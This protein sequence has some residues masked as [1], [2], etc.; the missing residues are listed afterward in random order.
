MSSLRSLERNIFP[1][2]YFSNC[3]RTEKLRANRSKSPLSVALFYFQGG[4]KDNKS[5]SRDFLTSL[6]KNTRETDIK[7]WVDQD[8]IGIILPDTDEKGLQRC[9]EKIKNGDENRNYRVVSATYPHFLFERL[10]AGTENPPDIFPIEL[11]EVWHSNA[12][13]RFGKRCMDIAGSFAGI[14][15]LSPLMVLIC[16][17]IKLDS[18]GPVIFRQIRHGEKGSRFGFLKFRSMATNCD[19]KA[20]REYVTNLIKGE[21]ERINQGDTEE[22][23]Y[24]MRSDPRVTRVGKVIRKTS[25]DE[26]PQLF[27]VLKGDMSLVGPR[28]PLPYEVEKYEPWHLRRILEVKPGITGLWQVDGRSKTSFDDMV[29][30]DLQYALNW[31][32]WLDMKILLKTVRAVIRPNG[33]V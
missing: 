18:S 16:L 25:I 8:V 4:T 13:S 10:L 24:K 9:L 33:A 27:N 29:R 1:K 15:I 7:A 5:S 17:A 12:L 30:L 19:D 23:L 31:S 11:D 28:P 20:H 2:S 26:L 21:H 3:L 14:V 22:P 32:L 6:Q